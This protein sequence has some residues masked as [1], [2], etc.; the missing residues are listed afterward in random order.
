MVGVINMNPANVGTR[1]FS[2]MNLPS[3]QKLQEGMITE[4]KPLARYEVLTTTLFA[5]ELDFFALLVDQIAS[6]KVCM[7]EVSTYLLLAEFGT[8]QGV[9]SWE[10]MHKVISKIIVTRARD[11]AREQQDRG[12]AAGID[13][14]AWSPETL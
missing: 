8:Q 12:A 10:E 6:V 4:T 9:M 3:L 5:E 7:R 14:D 2:S 11:D 1:L 13:I